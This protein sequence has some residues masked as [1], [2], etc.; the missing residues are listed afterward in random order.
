MAGGEYLRTEERSASFRNF[1]CVKCAAQAV[2]QN[3]PVQKRNVPVLLRND[4]LQKPK[5]PQHSPTCSQSKLLEDGTG[6]VRLFNNEE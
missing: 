2:L 3:D 5:A 6:R 4:P 1:L